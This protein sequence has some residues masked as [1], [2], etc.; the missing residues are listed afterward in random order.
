MPI[1]AAFA[2]PHTPQLLIRPETGDRD[3]V[4]RL[5]AALARVRERLAAARPDAICVLGG[6]HVEAFFL[7]AVPVLAVHAGA[8]VAGRFGR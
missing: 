3:L 1:V 5:H 2:L 8:R 4:L 7:N 6:D